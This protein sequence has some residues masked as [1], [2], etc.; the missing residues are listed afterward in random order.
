MKQMAERGKFIVFEG[1]DHSGKTTQAKIFAGWLNASGVP[2]VC[3]FEPTDDSVPGRA[4]RDVIRKKISL[5][6]EAAALLFVADRFEHVMNFILP[7]LERGV[8]VVS[9][10]FYLSNVAYQ[11]LGVD[12]DV[13][14]ALNEMIIAKKIRPDATIFLDVPP[15]ECLERIRRDSPQKDLFDELDTLAAVRE[16]YLA[17][18]GR[19]SEK[20]IILDAAG[21]DVEAAAE[22]IF[23]GLRKIS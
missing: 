23:S 16:N 8:T 1:L 11:G 19:V 4:A 18:F 20:I 10:R 9:D 2:A 22:K 21:L 13:L 17:A 5:H 14:L 12:T 15:E 7:N 3:T 6:A